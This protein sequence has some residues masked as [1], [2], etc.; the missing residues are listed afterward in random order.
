MVRGHAE[1]PRPCTL[2][3]Y[4]TLFRVLTNQLVRRE[5]SDAA[6]RESKQRLELALSGTSDGVWDWSIP[7]RM[8]WCSP[9]FRELLGYADEEC[10][11]D[12]MTFERSE[13]H[14]SELQSLMRISDAVFFLQ[15]TK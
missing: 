8:V 3:P 10:T 14:T 4:T 15:N 5:R 9:R 6:L 2:F 11:V 7:S 1:S 12:L 13:E